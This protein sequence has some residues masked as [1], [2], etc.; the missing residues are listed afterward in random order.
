LNK[1]CDVAKNLDV[2]E[3]GFIFEFSSLETFK[4]NSQILN[5]SKKI[6]FSIPDNYLRQVTSIKALIATDI[7][8]LFA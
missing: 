8:N 4:I 5:N 3:T 2:I 1:K 7:L 6:L